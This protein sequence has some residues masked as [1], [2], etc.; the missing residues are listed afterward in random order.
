[1]DR[2]FVEGFETQSG[3]LRE[4]IAGLSPE[5]LRARP[6]AGKWS[7][8]ELVTHVLDADLV[9]IDRMKRVIAMHRPL[10]MGFDETAYVERLPYQEQD[11]AAAA[12]IFRLGRGMMAGILKRLPND[13]FDRAG[14]H[15]E[16]GLVTLERLI[17]T[18]IAHVDHHMTFAREKRVALGKL[19]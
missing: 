17:V 4:A 1:M 15:S 13:A 14:V 18:Y 3:A 19:A 2:S 11:V 9:A 8:Q 6:I 5:E 10:L 12:E 7:M 16:N